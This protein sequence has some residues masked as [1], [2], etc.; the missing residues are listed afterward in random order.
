MLVQR[1]VPKKKPATRTES[2]SAGPANT[3][4]AAAAAVAPPTTSTATTST[5]GGNSGSGAAGANKKNVAKK[6]KTTQGETNVDRTSAAGGGGG[7]GVCSTT[8]TSG[9]VFHG[10]EFSRTNKRNFQRKRKA[11]AEKQQGE[12]AKKRILAVQKKN[13][14]KIKESAEE[15]QR[16]KREAKLLKKKKKE[17]EAN[18]NVVEVEKH[19]APEVLKQGQVQPDHH[20][21]EGGAAVEEGENADGTLAAAGGKKLTKNQKKNLRKKNLK[22]QA[23]G[24]GEDQDTAT[25]AGEDVAVEDHADHAAEAGTR[26]VAAVNISDKEC[27]T[28]VT[29]KREPHHN[30]GVGE[31]KADDHEQHDAAVEPPT[32]RQKK[33]KGEKDANDGESNNVANATDGTVKQEEEDDDVVMEDAEEQGQNQQAAAFDAA[34]AQAALSLEALR[35]ALQPGGAQAAMELQA[36]KA[37][38]AEQIRNNLQAAKKKIE[39]AIDFTKRYKVVLDHDEDDDAFLLNGPAGAEHVANTKSSGVVVTQANGTTK[40]VSSSNLDAYLLEQEEGS[41]GL[42]DAQEQRVRESNVRKTSTK[43]HQNR[44]QTPLDRNLVLLLKQNLHLTHFFPIQAQTLPFFLNNPDCDVLIGAPTGRGKTLAYLLPMLNF[45]KVDRVPHIS[46][47]V[48]VPT[49]ELVQQV[50][51]VV[52]SVYNFCP[53]QSTTTAEIHQNENSTKLHQDRNPLLDN[54]ARVLGLAGNGGEW[55]TFQKETRQLAGVEVVFEQTPTNVVNGHRFPRP[56]PQSTKMPDIVVTTIGK[57]VDHFYRGILGNRGV[58]SNLQFLVLDEA[59][60]LLSDTNTSN[61]WLEVVAKID[62][63]KQPWQKR[64]SFVPP[65][66]EFEL[67]TVKLGFRVEEEEDEEVTKGDIIAPTAS[68]CSATAKAASGSGSGT[69][70]TPRTLD[71]FDNVCPEILGPNADLAVAKAKFSRCEEED[72]N[73]SSCFDTK[74]SNL[75]PPRLRKILASATLTKNPRKLAQL[76]LQQPF[77]FVSTESG[78]YALPENLQQE[79]VFTRDRPRAMLSWLLS[80]LF[81]MH[82][83]AAPGAKVEAGSTCLSVLIFC[84]NVEETHK[85]CR[86]LQLFFELMKQSGEFFFAQEAGGTKQNPNQK[87]ELK[88][89]LQEIF[90]TEKSNIDITEFSSSLSQPERERL[91]RDFSSSSTSATVV[92]STSSSSQT[93]KQLKIMVCSDAAARGLDLP[94]VDV[95]VNFDVPAYLKTYIHRVGR[96]ARGTAGTA[97]CSRSN[98]AVSIVTLKT[99]KKLKLLL[100]NTEKGWKAVRYDNSTTKKELTFFKNTDFVG[101]KMGTSAVS[102]KNTDEDHQHRGETAMDE[103][104]AENGQKVTNKMNSTKPTSADAEEDGT[105]SSAEESGSD[106]S[107]ES[108]SDGEEHDA[109]KGRKK[110]KEALAEKNKKSAAI[111]ESSGKE[112]QKQS[113][114]NGDGHNSVESETEIEKLIKEDNSILRACLF[115]CK[116]SLPQVLAWEQDQ[117]TGGSKTSVVKMKKQILPPGMNSDKD[118]STL[119]SADKVDEAELANTSS[120]T[121]KKKKN[122]KTVDDD[123]ADDFVKQLTPGETL[124][125]FFEKAPGMLNS[126]TV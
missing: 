102:E 6:D 81:R 106:S 31:E 8:S 125:S 87:S 89:K 99:L 17:E 95:V 45:L 23:Q 15:K 122:K 93:K 86:F 88:N 85:L 9:S 98:R 75:G 74:T 30:A 114:K 33:A 92:P 53:G 113:V 54:P 36:A 72:D 18:A 77:F 69:T 22:K 42:E 96:T 79:S 121:K 50:V 107:T 28:P 71:F 91:V 5:S 27:A 83:G 2:Q 24:A 12:E 41:P 47:I 59:D 78:Q 116:D 46:S 48:V 111:G 67:N 84:G 43:R 66:N 37:K 119:A 117:K 118:K 70:T 105:S 11:V 4:A 65:L 124:K 52:E 3:T 60:R 55:S 39:K 44:H 14:W 103:D 21:D 64:R 80:E 29:S 57:F 126:L 1:F 10:V 112:T 40:V 49:R 120:K 109:N 61:K 101:K 25:A 110:K 123:V 51:E 82:S 7:A 97:S 16:R 73:R 76:N 100:R 19:V 62:L 13:E 94:Q 115:K 58:I 26:T 35:A 90:S 32:K 68:T 108:D 104:L 38:N 63:L 56:I 34:D 20:E